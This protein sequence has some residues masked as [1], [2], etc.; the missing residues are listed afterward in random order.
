[1]TSPWGGTSTLNTGTEIIQP[2]EEERLLGANLKNDLLW[3]THI[4]DHKKSII[5]TL[6]SK[7]NALQIISHYS[8]FCVRKM[9]ANGVIISHI[10]YH[11]QLYGGCTQELIS[12]L[13]VQQNRAARTVCKSPWGTSTKKLLDQIGW[14]SIKQMVAYYSLIT[15]HKTRQTGL[16][17]YLH[18]QIS[19]PFMFDTRV[20]R[21]GGIRAARNLTKGI[22]QSSFIPRSIDLWN[23]IP[24]ELRTDKCFKS[25]SCKL[26]VWVKNNIPI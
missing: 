23:T 19:Q 8:S 10:L 11:I 21:T 15:L 16:P 7:N 25:F 12:A 22:A 9:L 4:R 24:A 17:K 14:L 6:K 18:H 13:Q 20:A 3:N 1:M 5:A 26:R 2:S